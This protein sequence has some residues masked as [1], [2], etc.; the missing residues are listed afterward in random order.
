M[1]PQRLLLVGA[2]ALSLLGTAGCGSTSTDGVNP[3]AR[4]NDGSVSYSHHHRGT[5]SWHGGVDEWEPDGG[6]TNLD[7]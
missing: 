6:P 2:L 7:D 5:C 1:R 4:C 3:S